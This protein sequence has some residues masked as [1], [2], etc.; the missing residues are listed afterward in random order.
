MLS[1]ST[2]V[3]LNVNDAVNKKI[4]M[5]EFI[6]VKIVKDKEGKI[7]RVAGNADLFII[8]NAPVSVDDPVLKDSTLFQETKEV[9]NEI[10]DMNSIDRLTDN[11]K[12]I[13]VWFSAKEDF[14]CG[15]L[16]DHYGYIDDDEAEWDFRLQEQYLPARLLRNHL[17]GNVV[18]INLPVYIRNGS[19]RQKVRMELSTTL[20][21]SKYRYK[22][23]GNFEDVMKRFGL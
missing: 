7:T 14:K 22:N 8:P 13:Q 3:L 18:M 1:Q 9:M 4:E 17:E 2:L 19:D 11:D 10:C 21:Q 23:F 16:C 5:E 20:S 15:N 12:L 6:M